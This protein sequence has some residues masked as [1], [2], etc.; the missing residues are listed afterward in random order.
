MCQLTVEGE[1][2]L[3]D[4]QEN[5]TAYVQEAEEKLSHKQE[6]FMSEK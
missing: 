1:A 3:K 5:F 2:Q 6:S 4:V